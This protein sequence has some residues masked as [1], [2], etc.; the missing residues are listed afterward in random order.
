MK[1]TNINDANFDKL[2]EDSIPDIILVKK[3]YSH[4]KAARRKARVWK[5]KHIADEVA[6]MNK[7]N[8]Y[9]EKR[10]TKLINFVYCLIISIAFYSEYNEFLDDLE[11]DPEMRQNINIFR[12]VQK[13]IPVDTNE[14]DPSIPQITLEEMLD[15]LVIED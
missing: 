6:S 14:I 4:N 5:L 2:S 15:D 8:K 10:Y 1:D 7:E 9:V 11:E 13:Q 12:D 3:F